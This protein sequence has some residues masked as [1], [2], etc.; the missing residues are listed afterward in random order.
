MGERGKKR[1]MGK[2]WFQE[3]LPKS[4][5]NWSY[6]QLLQEHQISMVQSFYMKV[7]IV[8]LEVSSEKDNW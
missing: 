3:H 4:E 6:F 7:T 2:C 8:M 1:V 5:I